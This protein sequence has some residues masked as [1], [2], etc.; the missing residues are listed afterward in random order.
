MPSSSSPLLQSFGRSVETVHR[1]AV[2]EMLH[3]LAASTSDIEKILAELPASLAQG[4]PDHYTR[5][6]AYADPHGSFTIAYLIW[7][8]GQFSP[9]HGHRTWC[10]YRVLRGELT[11]THYN[12][13]LAT[14][15]ATHKGEVVRRP[16]DIVTGAPGFS[17][18][19]RLGNADTETAISLHI[20]GVAEK[21]LSTGVNHL[22]E[23][24]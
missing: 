23:A 19:H 12:W 24:T 15:K 18:I 20:Y 4:H 8:Q 2:H 11:E 10:A 9:I 7:R 16:G 5:H 21:D 3:E 1:H 17:Q 22:V 13:E 6:V 14:Q